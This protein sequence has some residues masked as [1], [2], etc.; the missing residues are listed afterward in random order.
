MPCARLGGP[1]GRAPSFSSPS[2]PAAAQDPR[3]KHLA[4]LP[5]WRPRAPS[6]MDRGA[7]F[8]GSLWRDLLGPGCWCRSPESRPGGRPFCFLPWRWIHPAGVWA[9]GLRR[10]HSPASLNMQAFYGM[11][12]KEA[13]TL[14]LFSL[15]QQTLPETSITEHLASVQLAP[16]QLSR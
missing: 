15:R 7:W 8:W 6:Y 11:T 4:G 10:A 3:N 13:Q 16:S 14:L 12:V 5:R 2:C 1:P 9:Q